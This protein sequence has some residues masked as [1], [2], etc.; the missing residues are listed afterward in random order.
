MRKQTVGTE[1][2]QLYDRLAN[3][4][5]D[6]NSPELKAAFKRYLFLTR[7]PENSNDSIFLIRASQGPS[8]LVL[9]LYVGLAVA[10]FVYWIRLIKKVIEADRASHREVLALKQRVKDSLDE[11]F[12]GWK[13]EDFNIPE[14]FFDELE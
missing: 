3:P 6:F 8:N 9:L 14:G 11:H 2:G 4:N 1:V 10:A 12:P 5:V 13:A 7:H